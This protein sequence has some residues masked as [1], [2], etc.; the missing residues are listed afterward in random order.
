MDF[1]LSGYRLYEAQE[2]QDFFRYIQ[3]AEYAALKKASPYQFIIKIGYGVHRGDGVYL[4]HGKFEDDIKADY[5]NGR[6][7]GTI[8]DNVVAQTYVDNP[9]LFK[10]HKFDFRI[11][12]FISSVDPFKVYYHDG[13]LRVS[14]FPFSKNSTESGAQI[15]NTEKAKTLI[16][17]LKK[18]NETHLNMTVEELMEF[19][20]QTLDQLGD[21][22]Y[23]T[24]K[25]S[26]PRWTD[27]YL[28]VQFKRAFLSLGK[29]VQKRLHKSANLFESFGVDFVID[30]DL[31][32][33]VIEVNASPMIVG[34]NKRKTE[35]MKGLLNGIFNITYAQQFSRTKR[36]LEFIQENEKEIKD[37]SGSELENLRA[38]F[39]E[40]YRNNV[41]AEYM[42]GLWNNPWKA[43]LDESLEG[44][45]KYMG[46]LS[47]E[48][49]DF[50]DSIA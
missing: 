3:G 41:E 24:G 20:M 2:C 22:L 39:R 15:T 11:Y 27:N 28:R 32:I 46:L 42:E 36:A 33:S 17:R 34:T 31:N 7:C 8:Q 50:M 13:F 19:Q 48:C 12:M 9:L 4:F 47:D 10:G 35:L 6:L 49:A 25:V 18:N 30:E 14:L 5:D 40:L 1:Y 38:K 21:Y 26:D 43:V 23:E 45:A 44:R 16:K 37:A 29:M